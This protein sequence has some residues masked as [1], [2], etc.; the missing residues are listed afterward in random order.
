MADAAVGGTRVCARHRIAHQFVAYCHRALPE[1]RGLRDRS[2]LYI[3]W[4][5]TVFK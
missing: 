4:R 2:N 3:S 1:R 5:A